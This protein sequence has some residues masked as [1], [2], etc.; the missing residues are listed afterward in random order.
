MLPA[1]LK[2][3]EFLIEWFVPALKDGLAACNGLS[4]DAIIDSIDCLRFM[5]FVVV[6]P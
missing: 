6:D 2:S 4:V 5:F 3:I 1:V